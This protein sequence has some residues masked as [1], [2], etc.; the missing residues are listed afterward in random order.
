[1][2]ST[3]ARVLLRL[4]SLIALLFLYVPLAIVVLYAFNNSIGQRWPITSFT[5]K[6]FGLAWRNPLVR[7]A[8][9]TSIQIAIGATILALLLGSMAAFAVHRFSFFGRN[10]ISLFLVLPIALPGIVTAMALNS[11]INTLGLP[12]GLATIIIGHATFCVVVVYNNVIARLRR[13]P[14]SLVE[15]SMDLGADGWQTFRYVTYPVI[16]TAIVAG[17]LLAFALSFDEIVVTNFVSGTQITIPKFIYNNVRQ[18][19]NRPIVNVVAVVLVLLSLIPVY[20]AQRLAGGVE[21]VGSSAR[22][23]GAD[24]ASADALVEEPGPG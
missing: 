13:S 6:Y 5:T 18:P 19:R 8:L 24:A 17:A 3:T 7:D 4:G 22:G 20:F 15:A 12:F 1:M 10:A 16:R 9:A 11:A 2:E 14:T 23:G 21:L